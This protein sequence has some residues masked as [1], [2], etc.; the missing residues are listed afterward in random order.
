[1]EDEKETIT[2]RNQEESPLLRLPAELRTK[3]YEFAIGGYVI[4]LFESKK[5]PC[6]N[7]L[8]QADGHYTA[9]AKPTVLSEICRQLYK[10]TAFLPYSLNTFHGHLRRIH[11][12]LK[13]LTMAQ[14]KQI[15]SLEIFFI[16]NDLFKG[17]WN[18]LFFSHKA[19]KNHAGWIR[20]TKGLE[21]LEY[22]FA[23]ANKSLA[24]EI[25]ATIR[26]VVRFPEHVQVEFKNLC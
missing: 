1:M 6:Y 21:R 26:E 3:I 5:K 20:A 10:E 4:E 2:C 17:D 18:S 25:E 16:R 15:K 13:S 8:S 7:V 11:R 19:L 22:S 12:F 9:F 23:E 14:R 24:E